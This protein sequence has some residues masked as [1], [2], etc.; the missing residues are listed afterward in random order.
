MLGLPTAY[1][2]G[3]DGAGERRDEGRVG[4]VMNDSAPFPCARIRPLTTTSLLT[5]RKDTPC[6]TLP[7]DQ[8]SSGS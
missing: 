1:R 6:P 3:G 7:R 4:V 5:A 2:G 8:H